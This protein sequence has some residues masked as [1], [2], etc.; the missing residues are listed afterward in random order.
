MNRFIKL[1]ATAALVMVSGLTARGQINLNLK[2]VTLKEAIAE[3]SR[4]NNISIV[5]SPGDVDLDRK[6]VVSASN[7]SLEDVLV[8]L[9]AGQEVSWKIDGRNVSVVRKEREEKAAPAPAP[10]QKTVF[11]KVVDASGEPVV[12]A[13]LKV[14][15][16]RAGFISGIDGSFEIKGVRFPAILLVS[17][18]GYEDRTIEVTGKEK[19]PVVIVL[20]DSWT[21]LDEI[22]VVW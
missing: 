2:D 17:S 6:V 22:V 11:G 20:E 7:A 16:T 15:G 18:M 19:S 12:G 13:G 4:T 21:T 9:F 1:L 14:E 8:R 10:A 3:L 5:V